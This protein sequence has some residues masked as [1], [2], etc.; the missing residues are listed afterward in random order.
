MPSIYYHPH[1]I[2]S[3]EMDRN[4]HVN[5]LRYLQ[6]C[7]DAAVAHSRAQGW[8]SERYRELGG[9]WVVR[10]H[11]IEYLAPCFAGEEVVVATWV[12]GFR[13]I[14]SLRKYLIRRRSDQQVVAK[15]ETWWAFVGIPSMAPRRVPEELKAA[16]DIVHDEPS[17]DWPDPS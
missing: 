2:I 8:A 5:N 15:A 6:W 10:S 14:R 17:L 12:A 7:V 1:E 3:D 13:R 16:F 9:S 11:G 4:G